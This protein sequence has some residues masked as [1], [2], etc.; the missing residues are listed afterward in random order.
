MIRPSHDAKIPRQDSNLNKSADNGAFP[1]SLPSTSFFC[2]SPSIWVQPVYTGKEK[3]ERRER[4]ARLSRVRTKNTPPPRP[5][6]PSYSH[7]LR[8]AISLFLFH[9]HFL[10]AFSG[11]LHRTLPRSSS[12]LPLSLTCTKS[13]SSINK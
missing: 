9:R 3:R 13:R 6:L 11:S 10:L 4:R 2:F 7:P 5:P 8:Y 1:S 12:Q